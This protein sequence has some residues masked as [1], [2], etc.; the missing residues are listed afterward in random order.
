MAHNIRAGK[1]CYN[2][3]IETIEKL[4]MKVQNGC[5]EAAVQAAQSRY[6]PRI[7]TTFNVGEIAQNDDQ[8]NLQAIFQN[9]P[10]D[11]LRF[12]DLYDLTAFQKMV[13]DLDKAKIF[14][15]RTG[16]NLGAGHFSYLHY[17][18]DRW[19]YSS[20]PT[21]HADLTNIRGKVIADVFDES[22]RIKTRDRCGAGNEQYA[23]FIDELS[24]PRTMAAMNYISLYRNTRPSDL[25]ELEV[26]D[27]LEQQLDS[28]NFF[29]RLSDESSGYWGVHPLLLQV[30]EPEQEICQRM[31]YQ[32]LVCK[33]GKPE[34]LQK[35]GALPGG[36]NVIQLTDLLHEA[37]R[38]NTCAS[39]SV[40]LEAGADIRLKNKQGQ[41]AFDVLTQ[42]R[43][44]AD[45]ELAAKPRRG[46]ED[47]SE[48]IFRAMI[49]A[50]STAEK[51]APAMKSAGQAASALANPSSAGALSKELSL[52]TVKY[53]YQ[54]QQH[55]IGNNFN[56]QAN[57]LIGQL[58]ILHN[59]AIGNPLL[60]LASRE[61][62][63]EGM[64]FADAL[65]GRYPSLILEKDKTSLCHRVAELSEM[66]GLVTTLLNAPLN[67]QNDKKL[68]DDICTRQKDMIAMYP[69]KRVSQTEQNFFLFAGSVFSLVGVALIISAIIFPIM[70]PAGLCGGAMMLG[71][72]AWGFKIAHDEKKPIAKAE[73]LEKIRSLYRKLSDVIE[74]ASD[75]PSQRQEHIVGMR[76]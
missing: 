52:L 42:A 43:L 3:N 1:S 8:I 39:V 15:T 30:N 24:L 68:T 2:L 66:V 51:K 44:F 4:L 6:F 55:K 53:G 67:I 13:D 59:T 34:Y 73:M 50:I 33:Q 20:G 69:S 7:Q 27:K 29:L 38:S 61:V 5:S 71:I 14:C 40:L 23:L 57:H 70:L 46:T 35:L 32:H 41:S 10:G 25:I 45:K 65:L 64:H 58:T 37:V 26:T 22:F 21:I 28:D 31:V 17:E 76:P 12:Y 16:Q 63:S 11:S 62:L 19:I 60:S 18:K 54:Q 48:F 47:T 9:F 56:E 36:L 75:N 49:K 72:G 74:H